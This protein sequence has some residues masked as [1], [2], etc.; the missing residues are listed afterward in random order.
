MGALFGMAMT[1]V[2]LC[3]R[4]KNKR[5]RDALIAVSEQLPQES[6]AKMRRA[7]WQSHHAPAKRV[8]VEERLENQR[9]DEES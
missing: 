7:A 3:L 5:Y 8:T 2:S 6:D 9:I 4:E 1:V